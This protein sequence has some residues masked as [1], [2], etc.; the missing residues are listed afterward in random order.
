MYTGRDRNPARELA[1]FEDLLDRAESIR[2]SGLRFHELRE[3]GLLYRRHMARLA[4]LRERGDD[5][6]A[7]RHLNA[8][9]LRAY[10]LLYGSRPAR[11][12]RRGSASR[13]AD[14]FE[15]S[16]SAIAA[17]FAL[18]FLGVFIG[19]ALS[20]REP[21]AL[22]TLVPESLGY[23]PTMLERLASS[24][25]EQRSFLDRNEVSTGMNT[26]FGSALFARNTRVGLLSFASG[27]LAGVPTVILQLYNGMILGAFASIFVGGPWT[28]EF[29]AWILPHAIPEFTAISLCAAGGLLLGRSVLAPG[30]HSRRVAFRQSM[31]SALLLFGVSVPLLFLAAGIESFVRESTLGVTTR[32]VLAGALAVGL[33]VVGLSVSRL[34]RRRRGETTWLSELRHAP[35]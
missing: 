1:R 28:L 22:W 20:A 12:T 9:A 6:D 18:I 19:A 33:G 21:Q 32:L 34:A 4:R 25:E 16:G 13:M 14:S 24:P 27:M 2:P 10:T 5:P 17:S 26:L 7:Q 11:G 29:L 15:R 23:T 35:E 30:A 8:L 31:D 3:L